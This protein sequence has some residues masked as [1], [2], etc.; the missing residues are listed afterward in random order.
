MTLT[1]HVR[2]LCAAVALVVLGSVGLSGCGGS[3][4][5]S[6]SAT[7]A[8]AAPSASTPEPTVAA[9]SRHPTCSAFVYPTL[10][11]TRITLAAGACLSFEHYSDIAAVITGVSPADGTLF[12]NL[13]ALTYRGLRAGSTVFS[14]DTKREICTATATCQVPNPVK[15]LTVT[16][17]KTG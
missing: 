6:S 12:E 4:D 8:A 11:T 17:T 16:V 1:R 9:E 2:P 14:V 10:R 15:R 5:Q 7:V 3:T 13:D